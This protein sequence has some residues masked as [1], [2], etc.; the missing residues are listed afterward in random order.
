MLLEIYQY[1]DQIKMSLPQVF[2]LAILFTLFWI[3]GVREMFSWFMKTSRIL[4]KLKNIDE[5]LARM[6]SLLTEKS[7]TSEAPA[8]EV[9]T[10]A[11]KFKKEVVLKKI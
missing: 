4:N 11:P 8:P 1:L 5:R 9:V 7:L 10:V 2:G 6:E 3:W